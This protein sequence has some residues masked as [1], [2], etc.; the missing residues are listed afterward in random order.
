MLL[1]LS[2]D[3]IG[4]DVELGAVTGQ[5]EAPIPFAAELAN[6]AEA[7]WRRDDSLNG[8]RAALLTALGPAALVEAAQTVAIFR[9]LNIAADSS[10][11][12]LDDDW[13]GFA[14]EFIVDLGLDKFSTAANTPGFL[15]AGDVLS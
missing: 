11:I 9:S 6:F 5:A 13:R 15:A 14:E 10:G 1:G 3:A 12:P 8:A 4:A 7:A 2:S